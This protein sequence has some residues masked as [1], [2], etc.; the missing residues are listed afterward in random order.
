MGLEGWGIDKWSLGGLYL[1]LQSLTIGIETNL[2]VNVFSHCEM[3]SYLQLKGL[4]YFIG[5]E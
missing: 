5:F 3:K 2:K 1:L 4:H